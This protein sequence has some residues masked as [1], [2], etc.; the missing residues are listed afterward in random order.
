MLRGRYETALQL[1][2]EKEDELEEKEHDMQQVKLMF[3]TQVEQLVQQNPARQANGQTTERKHVTRAAP[4]TATRCLPPDLLAT[5]CRPVSLLL[6]CCCCCV[7]L[8]AVHA[9]ASACSLAAAIHSRVRASPAVLASELPVT[10]YVA[11]L[12]P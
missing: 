11:V 2:G 12:L 5:C 6:R 3:R 9:T 4:Y 8:A 7:L 10:C 1:I